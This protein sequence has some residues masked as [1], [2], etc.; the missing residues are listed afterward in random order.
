MRYALIMAGGSG[1]RL[2]PMST[3][4]T[5]KQLIPFIQG[6]S[7]LQIAMER[8]EGLVPPERIYV[9]AGESTRQAMLDK[10][11]GLTPDRFIGEP[12]GRDTLNAVG[13]GC[14]VIGAKDPDAVV[15]VFTADHL[16]EPE[17]TFRGV[18]E[19]GYAVAESVDN[20][21]VTFGVEPTFAATGY[22][23]LELGDAI[24]G[25][26]GGARV[27]GRFQEKP[28][29]DTATK[30][31]AAGPDHYLWNSGMFVWKASVVMDCIRRYCPDNYPMLKA[32]GEGWGRPDV[33]KTLPEVF[34]GLKKISVDFAVMEPAGADDTVKVAAVPMPV[35][36]LD[37]GSWPSFKDTLEPDAHGNAG[38]GCKTLFMDAANNLVAG[39][40][41][42][43]LVSVL[44]LSDVVVIETETST[45]VCSAEA[46]QQIKALH[47]EV[48]ETFGK[49]YL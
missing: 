10:L 32:L 38:S 34:G 11:P 44:G 43:R 28:D 25:S 31:H 14:S 47:A 24:E 45:L 36:W 30:Y 39:T 15:A 3:K 40:D 46:A 33:M 26:A 4:E 48:A 9:V 1:T 7:L 13:L 49:A 37:V 2:W 23:Y 17:D 41:P 6:R 29:A 16:I 12:M 21:L 35:K 22:G 8:L 18:V 5:P 42:G 19:S 20:A 27:V